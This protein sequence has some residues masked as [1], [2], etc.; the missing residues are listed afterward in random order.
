MKHDGSDNETMMQYDRYSVK[1]EHMAPFKHGVRSKIPMQTF[2]LHILAWTVESRTPLCRMVFIGDARGCSRKCGY[3]PVKSFRFT[4]RCCEPGL[5]RQ[6]A[7]APEIINNRLGWL[8]VAQTANLSC[9]TGPGVCITALDTAPA[10][11]PSN[12]MPTPRRNADWG[13]DLL[14]WTFEAIVRRQMVSKLCWTTLKDVW[15]EAVHLCCF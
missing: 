9:S 15:I 14:Y 5:F 4:G 1:F 6:P 10:S 13:R 8:L 7:V 2:V 3:I 12:R 11:I